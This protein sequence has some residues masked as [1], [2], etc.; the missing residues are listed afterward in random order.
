MTNL[1]QAD[2][3]GLLPAVPWAV[4]ILVSLIAAIGDIRTHKIPNRITAPLLL[5]GVIWSAVI[6]GFAGLGQS[7]LATLLIGLPFFILWVINGSGAGDA[8][9]MG[10]VASWLGLSAGVTVLLGVALAGGALCIAYALARRQIVSTLGNVAAMSSAWLMLLSSPGTIAQRRQLMP[11]PL[12]SPV[13]YGLAIFLGIV[14]AAIWR[15]LWAS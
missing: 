3:S 13:P 9:M 12:S 15:A 2:A 6:G 14:A 7:L 4:V 8:K 10:A 1:H 11:Q 5:G